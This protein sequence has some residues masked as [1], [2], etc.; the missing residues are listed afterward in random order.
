MIARKAINL[1]LD[2]DFSA[3]SI[4]TFF[5]FILSSDW[6]VC[7]HNPKSSVLYNNKDAMHPSIGLNWFWI[8]FLKEWIKWSTSKATEWNEHNWNSLLRVCKSGGKEATW[9]LISWLLPA[10]SRSSALAESWELGGWAELRCARFSAWTNRLGDREAE[11]RPSS[12]DRSS[13]NK[14]PLSDLLLLLPSCYSPPSN[15]LQR[16]W[17]YIIKGAISPISSEICWIWGKRKSYT[18]TAYTGLQAIGFKLFRRKCRWNT[19]CLAPSSSLPR[20]AH[21]VNEEKWHVSRNQEL[22][23]HSHPFE[24]NPPTEY[25]LKLWTNIPVKHSVH[26]ILVWK[27]NSYEYLTGPVRKF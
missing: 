13:P 14:M 20:C 9:I 3:Q 15:N 10:A 26:E 8:T 16:V 23:W 6:T 12:L 7:V 25:P 21:I 4:S 27:N 22:L 24:N 18:H 5:H 2:V 19:L 17:A 11:R 1:G